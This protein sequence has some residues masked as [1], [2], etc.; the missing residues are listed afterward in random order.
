MENLATAVATVM[1]AD[2][3]NPIIQ[4]QGCGPKGTQKPDSL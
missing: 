1:S 3:R 2:V 4:G